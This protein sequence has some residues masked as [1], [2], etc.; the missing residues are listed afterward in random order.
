[1][2]LKSV[3]CPSGVKE[4]AGTTYDCKVTLHLVA[5]GQNAKGTI[6]VHIASGNKV[7]ILGRQ[8]VHVQ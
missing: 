6:T 1:V 8:D 5:S 7:E 2:T 4:T 3:N